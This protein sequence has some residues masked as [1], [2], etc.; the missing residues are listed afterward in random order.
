MNILRAA[1]KNNAAAFTGNYPDAAAGADP[2]LGIM[3]SPAAQD[4]ANP[5]YSNLATDAA[6]NTPTPPA[7]TAPEAAQPA[8][9]TAPEGNTPNDAESADQAKTAR[10]F[11]VTGYLY[12]KLRY[13]EPASK[14]ISAAARKLGKITSR[15]TGNERGKKSIP[16]ATALGLGVLVFKTGHSVMAAKGIHLPMPDF[17]DNLPVLGNRES[18]PSNQSTFVSVAESDTLSQGGAAAGAEAPAPTTPPAGIT[19]RLDQVVERLT[20]SDT[21]VKPA[22]GE[23]A[24][25]VSNHIFDQEAAKL[26]SDLRADDLTDKQLHQVQHAFTHD[27]TNKGKFYNGGQ[28][29]LGTEYHTGAARTAADELLGK[30]DH[31]VHIPAD[32]GAP[33]SPVEHPAAEQPTP[34]P[35]PQPTETPAAAPQPQPNGP[36]ASGDVVVPHSEAPD[37][38]SDGG[39]S[40]PHL[41]EPEFIADAKDWFRDTGGDINADIN[42]FYDKHGDAVFWTGITGIG[43]MLLGAAGIVVTHDGR[44]ARKEAKADRKQDAIVVKGS[45]RPL[46]QQELAV[47]A[48]QAIKAGLRT[49][50]NI[51]YGSPENLEPGEYAGKEYEEKVAQAKEFDEW[52]KTGGNRRSRVAPV[53]S[54]V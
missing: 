54:S 28:M 42:D 24:I 5:S 43:S 19:H 48:E 16:I 8:H 7:A 44:V 50:K 45:L 23:G 20:S 11:N 35:Q 41:H 1:L 14:A 32:G 25:K 53:K 10:S 18:S 12:A 34:A 4:E 26:G 36:S 6:E 31:N 2:G 9:A 49:R 51:E 33:A 37:S 22:K 46:S 13:G 15:F 39:P 21:T 40:L 29:N 3:R 52:L 38:S 27:T 47:R 30:L 17:L